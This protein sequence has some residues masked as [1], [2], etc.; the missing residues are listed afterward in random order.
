[1]VS[2]W[3]IVGIFFGS[4]FWLQF[5]ISVA[6]TRDLHS[7]FKNQSYAMSSN[8][9]ASILDE[10]LACIGQRIASILIQPA[11]KEHNY[12]ASLH[13]EVVGIP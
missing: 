5:L 8:E 13:N 1:M 2:L 7:C 3:L 6:V 4:T 11:E 9:G 12:I 10:A